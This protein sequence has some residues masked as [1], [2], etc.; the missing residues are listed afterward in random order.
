M[1]RAEIQLEIWLGLDNRK[2]FKGIFNASV[3]Q[4]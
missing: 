1:L 2:T 3:I 4:L